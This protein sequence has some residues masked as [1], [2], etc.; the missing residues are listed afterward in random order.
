MD[1]EKKIYAML[2]GKLYDVLKS[3]F[4]KSVATGLKFSTFLLLIYVN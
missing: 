1:S 4:E 2:V 3:E